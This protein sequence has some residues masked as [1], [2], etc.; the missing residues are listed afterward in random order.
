MEGYTQQGP[1]YR[2]VTVK[3]F[4]QNGNAHHHIGLVGPGATAGRSP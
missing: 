2:E 4:G 1:T 3:L